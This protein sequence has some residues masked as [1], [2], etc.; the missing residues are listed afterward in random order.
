MKVLLPL[1]FSFIAAVG[2]A[3]FVLSQK[4]T[5]SRNPLILVAVSAII[6]GLLTLIAV[7]YW[8]KCSLRD[9]VRENWVWMAVG[10]L[11][12]FVTYIAMN[13]L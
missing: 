9:V 11:S 10:G 7:P 3:M 5:D 13:L 1:L 4:R 8:G 12:L 2:N 6:C